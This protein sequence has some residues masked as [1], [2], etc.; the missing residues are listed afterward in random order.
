VPVADPYATKNFREGDVVKF[1][2]EVQGELT[3]VM[4]GFDKEGFA[5]VTVEG[6]DWRVEASRLVNGTEGL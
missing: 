5:I 4:L 6:N 2:S 1:V 3:G